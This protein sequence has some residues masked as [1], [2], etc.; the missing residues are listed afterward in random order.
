MAVV[1]QL[2][3]SRIN[4]LELSASDWSS[5]K[6]AEHRKRL[7]M[8]LCGIRGVAKNL[9]STQ[10]FAHISTTDCEVDHGGE[11]TQHQAMKEAIAHVVNF[12]P[13][14]RAEIEYPH[15]SRKWIIDVMAAS[16][17]GRRRYAFEVQLSCRP[18][19]AV[20]RRM[21]PLMH[22]PSIGEL[23]SLLEATDQGVISFRLE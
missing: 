16:D 17:D 19:T 10:F 8:P 21:E 1:A 7:T 18:S 9:D 12:V 13:G 2:D 6:A 5:L 15:P 11:S 14:W 3:G 4:A 23:P 20:L 22:R